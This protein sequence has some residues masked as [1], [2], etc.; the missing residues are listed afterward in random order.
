MTEAKKKVREE[1]TITE[2]AIHLDSKTK[3]NI[4]YN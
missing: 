2:Q 4:N 3:R 1:T